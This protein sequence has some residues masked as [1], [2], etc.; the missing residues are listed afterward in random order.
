MTEIHYRQQ[1]N[2]ILTDLA[3]ELDVPP[4]KYKEAKEH[5]EAVGDWLGEDDS[6]LAP[7]QPVIYPQGSFA[8][9]TA[10]KPLGNDDYDVDAVCLLQ[11]AEDQITQQQ[12]K[13]MVGDRLMHPRSRYKGML[14]PRH[15]GRRCWTIKYSDDSHFHLNTD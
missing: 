7:Y 14:D 4:S 8:L 11:F 5:Y 2:Q 6:E 10:V 9:G 1:L 3:N 13:Q 15:G 12:L